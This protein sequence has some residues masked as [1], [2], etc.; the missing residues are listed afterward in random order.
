MGRSGD[1]MVCGLATTCT[2]L[3][4]GDTMRWCAWPIMVCI[5]PSCRRS[6]RF[7]GTFRFRCAPEGWVVHWR[8]ASDAR[9]LAF[10]Q[11]V[12]WTGWGGSGS[13]LDVCGLPRAHKMCQL[14]SGHHTARSD[15]PLQGK[16]R[17]GLPAGRGAA[18]CSMSD[19][20]QCGAVGTV[21]LVRP[22]G[23]KHAARFIST[24]ALV[25]VT[26]HSRAIVSLACSVFVVS[27]WADRWDW[28]SVV[29][30]PHWSQQSGSGQCSAKFLLVCLHCLSTVGLGFATFVVLCGRAARADVFVL[31]FWHQGYVWQFLSHCVVNNLWG[32]WVGGEPGKTAGPVLWGAALRRTLQEG[33][34]KCVLRVSRWA[35]ENRGSHTVRSGHAPHTPG[36]TKGVLRVGG[37]PKK[38]APTHHVDKIINFFMNNCRNRNRE[39][40]EAHEKSLNEMDELM[41]FQSTTFDTIARRKL[42]E[43]LDTI[44]EF[45]GKIQKLQSEV[46]CVN[47]SRDFKD[48]GSVRSGL[49]HVANQL[50]SFPPHQFPRGLLQAV[51][52]ECRAATM[53]GN[54]FGTHMV[55]RE[56]FMQI[57]RRLLQHL[58][59][60]VKS[61]NF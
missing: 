10:G 40:R 1:T 38:T 3:R 34:K 8:G 22:A 18:R 37:E 45:I 32:M 48:V 21:V 53:R 24:V 60:K 25:T 41:R 56:T 51:L 52:L 57:Q 29:M 55:Y 58:S 36:W 26:L 14:S 23:R 16:P 59:A 35:L 49:S 13:D 28:V 12:V 7:G 31:A 42:V 61:L 17:S 30:F 15:T 6:G 47:D 33:P 5:G 19:V 46:N 50:V 39:L 11:Q 9:S 43:D 54:V 4:V 44:L 27:S 20:F 2:L